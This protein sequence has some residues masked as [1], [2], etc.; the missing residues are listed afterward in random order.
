MM[1]ATHFRMILVHIE[2]TS[3]YLL[4]MTYL[5]ILLTQLRCISINSIFIIYVHS[6]VNNLV[7]HSCFHLYILQVVYF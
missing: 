3:I 5:G 6:I 1:S 4:A 7:D 2:Q